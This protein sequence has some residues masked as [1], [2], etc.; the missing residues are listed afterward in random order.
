[1]NVIVVMGVA[2][3]GKTCVGAALAARLGLPFID[4]DDLHTDECRAQMADGRP[5]DDAQRDPWLTRVGDHAREAG[6]CVVAC[7]ALKAAH[8]ERLRQACAARF[9]WL[10]IDRDTARARLA[11]RAD[12]FFP[13]SLVDSQFEALQPPDDALHLDATAPI[14]ALV[15]DIEAA[16]AR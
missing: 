10:D 13:A 7:S 12:H 15:D 11:H 6:A 16:L 3:S 8:R 5:L 1:M 2:G 9:V 14:D 4:A